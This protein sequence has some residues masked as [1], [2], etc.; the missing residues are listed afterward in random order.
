MHVDLGLRRGVP[1]PEA[2]VARA[3]QIVEAHRRRP[4]PVGPRLAI[5]FHAEEVAA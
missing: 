1:F 2:A 3:R 4:W 5:R